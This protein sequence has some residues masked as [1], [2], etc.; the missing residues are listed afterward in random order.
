MRFWVV[1]QVLELGLLP[2]RLLEL[3]ASSSCCPTLVVVKICFGFGG[4]EELSIDGCRKE[5]WGSCFQCLLG[6]LR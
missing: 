4:I 5:D 3:R 1:W 6:L 2:L